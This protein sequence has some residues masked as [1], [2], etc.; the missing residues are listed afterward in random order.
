V[1]GYVNPRLHAKFLLLEKPP[2][3]DIVLPHVT[4]NSGEATCLRLLDRPLDQALPYP[5]AP[6]AGMNRNAVYQETLPILSLVDRLQDLDPILGENVLLLVTQPHS[7]KGIDHSDDALADDDTLVHGYET[8]APRKAASAMLYAASHQP[9]QHLLGRHLLQQKF[10]HSVAGRDGQFGQ[11]IGI[12]GQRSAKGL[13]L[14][15]FNIQLFRVHTGGT[16]AVA[17]LRSVNLPGHQKVN[18][19]ALKTLC[20]SL[21]LRD[22]QTYIQ[23]GNLVFRDKGENPVALARRLEGAMEASFG[24]RPAVIVRTASELRKVIAKN[25]FAERKE[26]EP[27]KLLVVFMDGAP[28]KQ[29][30][31][32]LLAI[33]CD[34]EE[35][36]I[37]G[38]EV[39]IYYPNGM[40]RPKIPLVRME[41]ALQCSSTGRNW[42]TVN[43]LLA[44]AE[45][46]E[47]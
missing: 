12:A 24:F 14:H 44:M 42:N 2:G 6:V 41:K 4:G 40:A 18:M 8:V 45:A 34:P 15:P 23:S 20:T 46:L 38:R 1:P 47:S 43:K 32:K 31:D 3:S 39:Y 33:P 28:T 29:A 19:Q 27:T 36:H 21:G 16:M 35:L 7:G 5:L 13:I 26:V 22:V 17:M 9:G 25:P 37:N 11:R 10:I 30:R